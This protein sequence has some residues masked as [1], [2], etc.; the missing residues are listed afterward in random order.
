LISVK[1]K[2]TDLQRWLF[3]IEKVKTAFKLWPGEMQ[4]KCATDYY[5]LLVRNILTRK[6]RFIEYNER[7][8]GWKEKYF[9]ARP[10]WV[11]KGDFLSSISI[12]KARNGYIT[13][14]PPGVMDTG[15]KSWLGTGTE[16]KVKEIAMYA[17]VGEFGKGP[18]P[19]G[20]HPPRPIFEPTAEEYASGKWI[21]RGKETLQKIK[22]A[23]S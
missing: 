14:V 3:A 10:F 2:E 19:G 8:G 13:G 9:P 20:K 22:L 18:G 7:Y 5:Q 12:M 23:W 15:G 16:G 17:K 21:E 11:L 6:Y 1:I 4:R